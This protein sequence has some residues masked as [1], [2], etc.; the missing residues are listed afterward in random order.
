M[1]FGNNVQKS[2][3]RRPSSLLVDH[4]IHSNSFVFL[5]H[6]VPSYFLVDQILICTLWSIHTNL[7]VAQ[8]KHNALSRFSSNSLS[9]CKGSFSLL[10]TFW[11]F[12]F[13]LRCDSEVT[14][15]VK[16]VSITHPY[17]PLIPKSLLKAAHRSYLIHTFF[18]MEYKKFVYNQFLIN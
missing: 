11:N 13:S 8:W 15:Y 17:F 1:K 12:T 14:S 18:R 16:M 10:F 5:S 9:P 2:E 3:V 4:C 7:S 6:Q